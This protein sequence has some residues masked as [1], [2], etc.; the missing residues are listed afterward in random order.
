MEIDSILEKAKKILIE[1]ENE[2]QK[3]LIQ[4][5][6][7]KTIIEAGLCPKCGEKLIKITENTDK[8]IND[9]NLNHFYDDVESIKMCSKDIT[10]F[11]KIKGYYWDD[12]DEA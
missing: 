8:F 6:R 1:R 3:E 7:D 5:Q 9:N 12:E 10:H 4:I 11:S 2:K